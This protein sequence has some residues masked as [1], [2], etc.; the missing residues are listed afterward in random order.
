MRIRWD[1]ATDDSILELYED[2]F[3]DN[4]V[5]EENHI[6]TIVPIG[7]TTGMTSSE[8]QEQLQVISED[9][10]DKSINSNFDETKNIINLFNANEAKRNMLRINKLGKLYDSITDQM[11]ERIEKRPDNFSNDDL[12]KYAK[13]TQDALKQSSEIINKV[14]EEPLIAVQQ[15]TVNVVNVEDNNRLTK[16]S[17]DRIT[18]AVK[19]ILDKLNKQQEP[20]VVYEQIDNE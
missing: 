3:E 14:K 16:E 20:E 5:S 18:G 1:E 15:N 7:K 8:V 19:S 13:V 4:D 17:R 10:I 6:L 11:V 2:E 9:L 12:V